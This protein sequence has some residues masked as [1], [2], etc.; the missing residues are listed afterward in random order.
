MNITKNNVINFIISLGLSSYLVAYS[1]GIYEFAIMIMLFSIGILFILNFSI[2]NSKK[3]YLLIFVS[4]MILF[5]S[6]MKY[7][8]IYTK[9]YLNYFLVFSVF[10]VLSINKNLNI[11]KVFKFSA[12]ILFICIPATIWIFI[13][14]D[15]IGILLAYSYNIILGYF[16]SVYLLKY[17]KKLSTIYKLI[18]WINIIFY[19][20]FLLVRGNR[21]VILLIVTYFILNFLMESKLK[22]KIYINFFIVILGFLFIYNFENVLL[23]F[24]TM[25]NYFGIEIDFISKT[26]EI[27][28]HNGNLDNGRFYLINLLFAN[29]KTLDDIIF[30]FGVG[31]IED[32]LNT[33]SHNI[34]V[35]Y[36]VEGGIIYFLVV[37]FI[38]IKSMYILISS[39][40]SLELKRIIMPLFLIVFVQL[41]LSNVYWL[42]PIY[43]FYCH[44]IT[45]IEAMRVY[46]E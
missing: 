20:L 32:Y 27:I 15:H 41:N 21:G 3:S 25:A 36:F 11:I 22:N 38:F 39:K 40:Y 14:E 7:D 28:K 1:I 45:N 12:I 6:L 13:N 29:Y 5:I 35:Q 18:Y 19:S 33:Y 44:L 42:V 10:S 2:L 26:L 9:V 30:G 23:Y 4:L 17:I 31:F 24:N 37:L 34:F 16:S 46:N 43:W 8:Y